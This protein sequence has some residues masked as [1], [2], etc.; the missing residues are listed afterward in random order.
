MRESFPRLDG[1][2]LSSSLLVSIQL[3][4]ILLQIDAVIFKFFVVPNLLEAC[5]ANVSGDEVHGMVWADVTVGENVDCHPNT[6]TTISIA[7]RSELIF[8]VPLI[9]FII[10]EV[11]IDKDFY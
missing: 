3:R 6:H 1:Q 4:L 10:R 8:C 9:H 2:E 11:W 5:V 7:G